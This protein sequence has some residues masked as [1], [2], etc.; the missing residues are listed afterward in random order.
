MKKGISHLILPD[1]QIRPGDDLS[2]LS[3]IGQYIVDKKPDVV[4]MLGDWADMHSLSSYDMGRKSGEGSRYI[5]DIQAANNGLEVLTAPIKE[6]NNRRRRNKKSLYTPRM[7]VTLGNHE[8]R[9]NKHI[10]SYPILSDVLSTDA[11]QFKEYGFEVYDFLEVVVID[12]VAYSHFFP[13]GPNG[14]IMQTYRGAPNARTQVIR[15]GRSCTAGHLQGL[16]WAVHPTGHSIQYGLIAGSCYTHEEEY[17]SPQGTKYWRGV[18]MKHG[19]HDGEYNPM[20]VDLGY[21][22]NRYG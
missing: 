16:D 15:E 6:Y 11:I 4:V 3:W 18:I 22:G 17:L 10:N 5:E 2:Y 7:V 19:V 8:N 1:T 12:G 14:R 21:L 13:R 9:I 20:M